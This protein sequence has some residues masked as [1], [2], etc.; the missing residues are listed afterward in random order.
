[1]ISNLKSKQAVEK[2]RSDCFDRLRAC[3]ESVEGTSGGA[4]IS[5]TISV[6]AEALEAF[7]IFLNSL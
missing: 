7:R 5:L 1:M 4:L 3:P 6:H 2:P